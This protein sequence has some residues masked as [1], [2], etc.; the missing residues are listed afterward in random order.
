MASGE[1]FSLFDLSP[2][3]SPLC[4]SPTQTPSSVSNVQ[5]V[6]SHQAH[7][8]PILIDY[9]E[10]VLNDLN[11]LHLTL[12]GHG[13]SLKTLLELQQRLLQIPNLERSPKLSALIEMVELRG[14]VELAK[15]G[16]IK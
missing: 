13:D 14:H 5:P 3:A 2:I 11:T 10:S 16:L 1:N 4:V 12:L 7:N 6:N 15:R 8:E 9:A